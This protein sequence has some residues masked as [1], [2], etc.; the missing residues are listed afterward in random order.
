MIYVAE[1]QMLQ[2]TQLLCYY[3]FFRK[4]GGNKKKFL[5]TFTAPPTTW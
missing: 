2:F 1:Y 4:G 5:F 3:F